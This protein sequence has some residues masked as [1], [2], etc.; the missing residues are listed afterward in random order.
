MAAGVKGLV[1]EA[2]AGLGSAA[3]AAKGWVAAAT[4]LA[5]A[6]EQG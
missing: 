6:E 5:A 2:A 1:A 3:A 4:G